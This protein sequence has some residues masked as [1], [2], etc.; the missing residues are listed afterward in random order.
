MI[1]AAKKAPAKSGK[2][3]SKAEQQARQNQRSARSKAADSR[4]TSA[5]TYK[6]PVTEEQFARW[7]K[8]PGRY[9]LEGVDT[10]K[11]SSAK[12]TSS[13]AAPKKASAPKAKTSPKSTAKAS[14]ADKGE[15][16]RVYGVPNRHDQPEEVVG[17]FPTLKEAETAADA[18]VKEPGFS[19]VYVIRDKDDDRNASLSERYLK[20][21][22]L[23]GDADSLFPE[24]FDEN[25]TTRKT[26]ASKSHLEPRTS[27]QNEMLAKGRMTGVYL[28]SDGAVI[29]ADL[30]DEAP[31]P[32]DY[33]DDAVGQVSYEIF[34]A[35]YEWSDLYV[36]TEDS[37]LKDLFEY[38]ESDYTS[39]KVVGRIERSFREFWSI[40]A[41]DPEQRAAYVE[42]RT[43]G[44]KLGVSKSK[45]I[46]LKSKSKASKS[47]GAVR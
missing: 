29:T 44:I 6:Q 40:D 13:K 19:Y 7:S 41:D 15:G 17:W 5:R 18:M 12:K 38:I 1:M 14:K 42:R 37:T 32:D 9:D 39:A 27:I 45:K 26:S 34:G 21:V 22:Y 35:G 28:L 36:F 46:G 23:T 24:P 10:K 11:K 4:A 33:G 30:S 16:Y 3:V 20:A 43:G 47:R 31:D 25:S 8:T 2:T